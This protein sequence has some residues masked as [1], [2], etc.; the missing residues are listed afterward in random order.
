MSTL[1]KKTNAP[2]PSRRPGRR[3]SRSNGL[4]LK[5][6]RVWKSWEQ[7][8]TGGQTE[9]ATLEMGEVGQLITRSGSFRVLREDDFQHLAGL[10]R[11]VDRVQGGL[12]VIITAARAVRE[13]RDE[14]TVNTLVEVLTYIGDIPALPTRDR[15]EPMR[16]ENPDAD[17][18]DEV[19]L[20]PAVLRRSLSG[21][22]TQ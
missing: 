6:G 22:P 21:A 10:A 11:D 20:D 18:D 17:P 14:A 5:P 3:K 12:N 4:A 1:T 2:L 19:E 7:F 16:P 15:F 8:R 13:H 9:L